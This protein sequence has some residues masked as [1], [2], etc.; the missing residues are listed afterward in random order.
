[1]AR[2]FPS[3]ISRLELAGVHPPELE[4]LRELRDRLPA[5]YHVYHGVHWS[6]EYSAKRIAF[7]EVDFAVVNTSGGVVLIEQKNG[8]LLE[9]GDELVKRYADGDKNVNDQIRRSVD[10][11]KEKFKRQNGQP[12]T[13]VD[14][15]I[16]CPDYRV[17][18][19]NAATLDRSRIVDAT[20]VGGLAARIQS[21]LG[22]G[23]ADRTGFADRVHGFLRQTLD[24]VVDI[25]TRIAAQERAFIR[26]SGDLARFISR[27]Q[28]APLK[29]RISGKAGCGKSLLARETFDRAITDGHRPLLV[30]FNRNLAERLRPLV[31][32]GGYVD[33]FYGFCTRFLASRGQRVDFS[34][35]EGNPRF[36]NEVQEQVIA[37]SIGEEWQFD[38]L[39]VD[40]GQD[41]E[42]EWLDI[43]QLFLTSDANTLWLEDPDQNVYDKPPVALPGF[44]TY[45]AEDNFR[46][47][48]RIARFIQG[49][50]PFEFQ[51]GNDLPGFD[52]VV[53]GYDDPDEQRKIV[54]RVCTELTRD[55][56]D[57]ND[58]VVLTCRG[59]NSSVF[60]ELEKVGHLTLRRFTGD[61]D[62]FGNQTLTEGRLTFDSV[63]RFKGQQA[64]AVVL[65]DID[66]GDLQADRYQRLLY[67]GMTRATV[68]LVLVARRVP[69]NDHL[70][71]DGKAA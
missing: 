53:H 19:L 11:V 22:P 46:S 28:M 1:M 10:N 26:R 63:R 8:P 12:L 67:C 45:R 39:I 43:L 14:Y 71:A 57:A 36:W 69:A 62:L 66:P 32:E 20:A 70:F 51:L 38:T 48:E 50:L 30:C 60:S 37:E 2:I 58:I 16:Y 35:Q 49:T 5:Q 42:Q 23:I 7:G 33:T 59:A 47:P 4:T 25:H 64:P 34:R 18:H 55:G 21:I 17:R 9:L 68:R 44:A 52:V 13:T 40:E 54:A 56:F 6:R 24:L 3:D 65:V 29:L 61:Y 41:F 31:R 15:L 27:F